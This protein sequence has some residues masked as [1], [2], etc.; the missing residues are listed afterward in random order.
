MSLEPGPITAGRIRRRQGWAI[1]L[2][3]S[4]VLWLALAAIGYGVFSLW[5]VVG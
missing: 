1:A 2:G 3:L 5:S 4:I